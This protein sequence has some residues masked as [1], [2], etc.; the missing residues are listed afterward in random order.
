MST[1]DLYKPL[2]NNLRQVCLLESLGVIRAYVQHLQFG[3]PFP[4]DIQVNDE[5]LKAN[6]RADKGVFEWELELL[7]KEIILNSPDRSACPKTLRRWR[8][9]AG[10]VNKLRDLEN[11]IAG[12]YQEIF[13]QNIMLELYRIAHR[14]FPWQRPPSSSKF[15]RHF[16]IFSHPVL[17]R[18]LQR[19]I[20][21][22]TNELY[23]LGLATS[24]HYLDTFELDYPPQFEIPGVS[25]ESID[26]FVAHFS[27]DIPTLKSE[28][29]SH[30]SYDQDYAYTFNPLKVFPLIQVTLN[31]KPTLVAPLPTFLIRRFSEGIYYEICNEPGFPK[32]FGEAF[33]G[34]V[35]EAIQTINENGKL[36][37]L[38]EEEYFVGRN[39]KDSVDWIV[40]DDSGCLLI[41]CKTKRLRY[42]SK[43]S[44][45]STEALDEDFDKMATFVLQAY[46]SRADCVD[47]RYNHWKPTEHEIF[48]VIVT[49]EDWYAF[50]DRII[51]QELDK[52]I[53]SGL[54]AAGINPSII[55]QAPYTVCSVGDLERAIQIMYRVGINKFM[56]G[57]TTGE[58]RLW[59]LDSF[60]RDEFPTEF[61]RL[62]ENL[63]ADDYKKIHPLLE[64]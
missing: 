18:L 43:I 61:R 19:R 3:R 38:P 39:R 2:R 32:A 42:G 41:E 54:R 4:H 30:K 60:M 50:G 20:G 57:K 22:K 46:K 44:L 33:Q 58:K 1:Y 11:N 8:D 24:G 48:P 21:L 29:I 37:V 23:T 26:R 28:I 6:D 16:R 35:G 10:V 36:I 5:F 52:R 64:D 55:E 53:S 56:Q 62:R 14:Q 9:F 7:A 45:T 51:S 12:R 59:T 17:E 49:L 27:A 47:C 15:I 34:Y 25:A 63:F 40:A 13:E 31:G